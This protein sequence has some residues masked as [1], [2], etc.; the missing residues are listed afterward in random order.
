MVHVPPLDPSLKGKNVQ[1][2]FFDANMQEEHIVSYDTYIHH[3]FMEIANDL[4][5][6]DETGQK[7]FEVL[8]NTKKVK[9]DPYL[10]APSNGEQ[11]S[12]LEDEEMGQSP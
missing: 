9:Y 7:L 5:D 3:H 6:Q 4:L 11:D 8:K 2:K 10:D 12:S 1:V